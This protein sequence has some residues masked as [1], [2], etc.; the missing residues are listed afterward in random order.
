MFCD[1]LFSFKSTKNNV[2]TYTMTHKLQALQ[3]E[4]ILFVQL[5]QPQ[6]SQRDRIARRGLL[7]MAA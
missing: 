7:G 1:V 3:Q 6:V 5:S 2:D 4:E